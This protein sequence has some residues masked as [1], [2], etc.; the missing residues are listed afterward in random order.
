[1]MKTVAAIPETNFGKIVPSHCGTFVRKGFE[2]VSAALQTYR[3][4][5]RDKMAKLL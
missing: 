5:E 4:C 3:D 1:M 2:A